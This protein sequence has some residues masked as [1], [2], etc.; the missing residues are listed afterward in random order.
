M[1]KFTR[2]LNVNCESF[3][4]DECKNKASIYIYIYLKFDSWGLRDLKKSISIKQ[5]NWKQWYSDKR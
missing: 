2:V 5:F 1:V 3:K 4:I